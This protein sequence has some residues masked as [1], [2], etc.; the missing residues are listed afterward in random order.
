LT[1]AYC[2]VSLIL[3]Y[4]GLPRYY[5]EPYQ[6]APVREEFFYAPYWR[7]RGMAVSGSLSRGEERFVDMAWPAADLPFLPSELGLSARVF[8]MCLLSSQKKGKFFKTRISNGEIE[9]HSVAIETGATVPDKGSSLGLERVI[10]PT[11]SLVYVP[12]FIRGEQVFDGLGNRP[13]K[14]KARVDLE[15]FPMEEQDPSWLVRFKPALCP[16]C[17]SDLQGEKE[18][19]VFLCRNCDRAWESHQ[20]GLKKVDFRFLPAGSQPSSYWLPFWKIG[21][22]IKGSFTPGYS[23]VPGSTGGRGSEPKPNNETPLWFPAFKI[24]PS[25]FITITRAINFRPPPTLRFKEK[26]FPGTCHPVTLSEAQA[27]SG[28]AALGPP[29]LKTYPFNRDPSSLK[30]SGSPLLVYLPFRLQ[31]NEWVQEDISLGINKNAL[32]FGRLL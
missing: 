17:G 13:L 9:P 24:S 26:T 7:T 29:F 4:P 23:F 5:L 28:M 22:G 2:R 32:K 19:Y 18:S 10:A 16:Y 11:A 3:L 12:I 1:C 8:R 21:N 27:L 6:P 14:L 15:E 20:D 31:G 25:L 30:P